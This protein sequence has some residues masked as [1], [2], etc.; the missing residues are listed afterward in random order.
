MHNHIIVYR[1][2]I[3]AIDDCKATPFSLQDI[4]DVSDVSKSSVL[5]LLKSLVEMRLVTHG[6]KGYKGKRYK[7]TTR[8]IGVAEVIEAYQYAK[9]IKLV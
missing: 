1:A 7:V 8:W 5:R 9:V 6:L 2:I 4:V 3:K